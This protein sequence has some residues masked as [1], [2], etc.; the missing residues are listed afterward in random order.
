M[1]TETRKIRTSQI[2]LV[3]LV[4]DRCHRRVP[5]DEAG[6]FIRVRHAAGYASVWG[7]GNTVD[8][9]LCEPCFHALMASFA[10]VTPDAGVPSSKVKL[11]GLAPVPR[12]GKRMKG[13]SAGVL[14][15]I[16][17]D[18]RFSEE[19]S[20][21]SAME[22]AGRGRGAITHLK[23]ILPVGKRPVPVSAMSPAGARKGAGRLVD[24]LS[25]IPNVGRD[26]DFARHSAK[27]KPGKIR[28]GVL[29]G[30]IRVAAD[31]DAPVSNPSADLNSQ[32][33][34]RQAQRKGQASNASSTELLAAANAARKSAN[35]AD[36]VIDKVQQKKAE[37]TKRIG[38][39]ELRGRS[40]TTARKRLKP[41]R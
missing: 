38:T 32:R 24:V 29:K 33:E 36:A 14:K 15:G 26:E 23:G 21:D 9:D 13:P 7:D 19:E 10:R 6:D 22:A 37:S 30:K 2:L 27:A 18:T 17:I 41:G 34:V 8:V 35:R 5:I 25:E 20:R 40:A 16:Q 3:A 11:G 4:C 39:M 31:F 28:F 1:A 12:S